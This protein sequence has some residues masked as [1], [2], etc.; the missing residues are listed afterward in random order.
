MSLG[1]RRIVAMFVVVALVYIVFFLLSEYAPDLW[2][3]SYG[4][5][6]VLWVFVNILDT[7]STMLG[8]ALLGPEH[9]ATPLMRWAMKAL[10]PT[11]GLVLIKVIFVPVLIMVCRAVPLVLGT[12][13]IVVFLVSLNNYFGYWRYTRHQPRT[14]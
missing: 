13:T 11:A 3:M 1:T 14:G 12:W 7:H 4:W 5:I 9:E 2:G 8:L 10:G 6:A